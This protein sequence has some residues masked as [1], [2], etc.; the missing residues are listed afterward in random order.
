MIHAVRPELVG[1][2][3]VEWHSCIVSKSFE[4]AILL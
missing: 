2:K 1:A 3:I 4:Q